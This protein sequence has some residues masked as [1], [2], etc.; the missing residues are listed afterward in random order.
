MKEDEE[1]RVVL[2]KGEEDKEEK[3]RWGERRERRRKKMKRKHYPGTNRP[4]RSQGDQSRVPGDLHTSDQHYHG[5]VCL[6]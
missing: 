1:V 6:L 2:V 5:A 4:T 3:S